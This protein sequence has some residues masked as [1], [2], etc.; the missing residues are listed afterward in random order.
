[1]L[2]PND[3]ARLLSF[4]A[5][6]KA[7]NHNTGPIRIA[8]VGSSG[9]LLYR[10]R[11]EHIDSYD[12]VLRM[13]GAPS[14]RGY[15]D[16]VGHTSEICVGN[17]V[18]LWDA[19]A[20]HMLGGSGAPFAAIAYN[21]IVGSYGTGIDQARAAHVLYSTI[22]KDFVNYLRTYTLGTVEFP[23]TGFV[24]IS[25]AVALARHLGGQPPLVVGFG[26]CLECNKYYDCDGSNSTGSVKASEAG[27]FDQDH[28]FG[29]EAIVRSQWH[30]VNL[31]Y[32]REESCTGFPHYPAD[33]EESAAAV[34]EH[35][36][37]YVEYP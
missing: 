12:L 15:G 30:S 26:A 25:M 3:A 20:A 6:A 37:T 22:T 16:D 35:P 7:D 14:G 27:G 11:G 28:P 32:L 24:A 1:M 33:F 19:R 8:V 2:S 31:I 4:A 9:N 29:T 23:S 34:P 18:G 17:A 10:G 21:G 36:G 13:N 5:K